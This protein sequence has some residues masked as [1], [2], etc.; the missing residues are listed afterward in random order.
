MVLQNLSSLPH[1][2]ATPSEQESVIV[3]VTDTDSLASEKVLRE[4]IKNLPGVDH[5]SLTFG[6][7]DPDEQGVS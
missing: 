4:Q 5:C 3:L 1:C 2:E 6:E 7:I